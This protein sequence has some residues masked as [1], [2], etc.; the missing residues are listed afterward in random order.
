MKPRLDIISASFKQ[1]GLVMS[2]I[3]WVSKLKTGIDKLNFILF[4]SLTAS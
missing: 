2:I 4:C 1:L 3:Q